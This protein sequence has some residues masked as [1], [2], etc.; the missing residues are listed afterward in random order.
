MKQKTPVLQPTIRP[1]VRH[2]IR[3]ALRLCHLYPKEM[4]TYADKGNI[5]VIRQRLKWRDLDLEL[6]EMGVGEELTPKAANEIDLVY[7]GGGQDLNQLLI[8]Q[9]FL[10][11]KAPALRETL[12]G[13]SS[14]QTAGLFICGGYQLAGQRYTLNG[15][16][17]FEGAG[18]FETVSTQTATNRLVGNIAISATIEDTKL[19]ILGYENHAG[20]TH[21]IEEGLSENKTQS[22]NKASNP[23]GKVI[24]GNGNNDADDTEGAITARSIGTYMHGPLLPKNPILADIL[25]RWGLEHHYGESPKL[26]TLDDSFAT[27]ARNHFLPN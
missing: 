6:N 12:I 23:L 14:P 24:Y 11:T 26:S 5:S 21:L 2:A 1:A 18:I 15:D 3:P 27:M 22:K 13:D 20:R 25:I 4:N 10:K 9:D 19:D 17:M 16:T 8:S 7:M